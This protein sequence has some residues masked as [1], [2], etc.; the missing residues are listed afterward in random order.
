MNRTAVLFHFI[1]LW[2]RTFSNLKNVGANLVLIMQV[3]SRK[4][5]SPGVFFLLVQNTA[6][7][8]TCGWEARRLT[9][10]GKEPKW[11]WNVMWSSSANGHRFAQIK[12]GIQRTSR[13]IC[14]DTLEWNEYKY[15]WEIERLI[16]N[17]G[18]FCDEAGV[19]LANLIEIFKISKYA[20]VWNRSI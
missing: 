5:Q 20:T 1:F 16:D 6:R 13:G 17:D 8:K 4:M 2:L 9:G 14:G 11:R 10:R 18:G 7:F 15:L 3:A 12:R 19:C